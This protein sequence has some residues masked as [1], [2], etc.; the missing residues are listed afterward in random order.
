MLSS[1]EFKAVS[2]QL[3]NNKHFCKLASGEW[4]SF[5]RLLLRIV[6]TEASPRTSSTSR[7]RVSGR[8]FH[9]FVVGSSSFFDFFHSLMDSLT[10]RPL[11]SVALCGLFVRT[12]L[13]L[14]RQRSSTK[15]AHKTVLL[16]FKKERER[17]SNL[18]KKKTIQ[19]STKVTT[20]FRREVSACMTVGKTL[21]KEHHTYKKTVV[22]S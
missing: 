3:I 11:V 17:G 4:R 8:S 7:G 14:H 16:L 5:Q 12:R 9:I 1:Q 18:F 2:C 13:L 21:K 19:A 20:Y 15:N 22:V 10:R 6:R